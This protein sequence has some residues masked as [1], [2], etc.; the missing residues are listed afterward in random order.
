MIYEVY[1][2]TAPEHLGGAEVHIANVKLT[3]D[4]LFSKMGDELLYFRH[5]P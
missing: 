1:G 3:T 2:F 4:L 5:R